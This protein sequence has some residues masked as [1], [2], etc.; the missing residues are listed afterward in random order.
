MCG[1]AALHT[2]PRFSRFTCVGDSNFARWFLQKLEVYNLQ[3][4]VAQTYAVPLSRA[5][6]AVLPFV[7]FPNV[8]AT[9]L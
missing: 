1:G 7:Q 6:A 5:S 8:S 4:L 2:H 3:P 9:I